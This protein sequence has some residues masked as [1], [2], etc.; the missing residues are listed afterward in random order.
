MLLKQ[1]YLLPASILLS[2]LILASAWIYDLGLGAADKKEIAAEASVSELESQLFPPDGILL[3]V[4]WGN[5]G[6][7]MIE[8]GVIDLKKLEELYA[9]R[10][11]L[12]AEERQLLTDENNEPL[13]L[14]GHNAAFLLNLFW[15]LGLS[16][17]N[18]ILENGPMTDPRYG[19]PGSFAS[20]G[21]W[22]LAKG[23]AM[24]HYS[25]HAFLN[26][27]LEQQALVEKVSKNIYRPCCNN[28]TYFPDCNHGMAMLGFL[29][30]MAAQGADEKEMYQFAWRLNSFWFPD[31]ALTVAKYLETK[32]TEWVA[33]D[34][35]ALSGADFFSAS[36][37]RKIQS[38][39]VLPQ[40]N[41]GGGCGVEAEVSS[42]APA[43][44]SGGCGV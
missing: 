10:G 4:R 35:K 20:T 2:A 7:Q 43:K 33:A 41:Q 34:P 23:E 19:D 42:G 3:P 5:L 25:K 12:S 6:K 27:T 26:L 1:D 36:G 40:Q 39:V 22:T 11:G 44:S 24:E 30:L 14:N 31:Q 13:V 32:G 28:S 38:S 9:G 21:G 8:A 15:A 29:E 18:E 17:K 37:Y 16:S